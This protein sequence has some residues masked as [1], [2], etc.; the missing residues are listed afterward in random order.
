MNRFY[1][2]KYPFAKFFAP[3]GGAGSGGGANPPAPPTPPANPPAPNPPQPNPLNDEIAKKAAEAVAKQMEEQKKAA[4]EAAKAAAQQQ[5]LEG[6]KQKGD[7]KVLYEQSQAELAAARLERDSYKDRFVKAQSEFITNAAVAK[8]EA[9]AVNPQTL[10]RLL[11]FTKI[12]IVNGALVGLDQQIDA[13]RTSDPYLFKNGTTP[14]AGAGFGG[15]GNPP[16]PQGG[17]A[18]SKEIDDFV[19]NMATKGAQGGKKP[20][21][22]FSNN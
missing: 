19:K 10:I 11:D 5:Q 7:Y 12:T 13:L 20:Y 9:V 3:D 2:N 15:N 17:K 16:S 4:E 21:D 14:P 6:A 22:H 8:L 18:T 1:F